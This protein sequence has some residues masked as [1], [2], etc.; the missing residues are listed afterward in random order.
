MEDVRNKLDDDVEEI[1]DSARQFMDW[2]T[3]VEK[4]PWVCVG[5]A[6]AIGYFVVPKRLRLKR[7]D[8]DDAARNG[9]ER[10]NRS[11][12]Q[13]LHPRCETA[14]PTNC[15]ALSCM[16]PCGVRQCIWARNC[17]RQRLAGC[18]HGSN[19]LPPK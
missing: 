9:Q 12:R 16:Q 7:P 14:W 18:P 13:T 8:V 19:P 11:S 17:A 5:L 2:H 4:Y 10:T 3:Y 15:L 1:V 6:T